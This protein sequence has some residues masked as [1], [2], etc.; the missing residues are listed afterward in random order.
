MRLADY[1]Y[2]AHFY[3]AGRLNGQEVIQENRQFGWRFFPPAAARTPRPVTL[4]HIKPAGTCRVFVFGESAA[5][6][7]PSPAFGMPRMLEVLLR[8]RYPNT[9]FEVV[10]AAM[11]AINSNVILPI[12]RDCAREQG[13][14]WV[15][16]M[17]NNEVVGPYGAGTVFGPQ[18]PSLGFIRASIALKATKMGQMFEGFWVWLRRAK[19]GLPSTISLELFLDHPLRPDDPLMAKV[20]AHFARNLGDI[21]E[22]GVRSG[23]K[24]VVSTVASNLKD[25]PP[26]ASLHR[27]DLSEAQKAEW[28]GFYQAGVKAETEG[29]WAAAA[30]AYGRAAGI[31]DHYAELRFR[32]GRAAWRSGDFEA[33]G[34]HFLAARDEDG[35]RVRADRRI[36]EIIRQVGSNRQ[37]QGIAFVDGNQALAKQSPH[38]V[39]G[40]ELLYEHVHL[41]FKGNY[42]LARSLAEAIESLKPTALAGGTAAVGDWLPE[43]GCASRLGLNDWNHYQTLR[44]LRER[45]EHPPFTGQ[46][47]H[48]ER[49]E[50]L[51]QEIA[52][53]RASLTPETLATA[54]Q[55]CRRAVSLNPDDWT[56]HQELAQLLGHGADKAAAVAEWERVVAVVPLYPEPHY[57]LGV[58]LSQQGRTAEAITELRRALKLKP[59]LHQALNALGSALA[60]QSRF[61]EAIPQYEQALR[62]KPDFADARVN[63]GV[64][65][66]QMGRNQEAKAQFE[67]ALHLEP[68]HLEASRHLGQ[69]LNQGGQLSEVAQNY[70]EAVQ[71]NPQDA[72]AHFKWGQALRALGRV[73]EARTQYAEA[74]RINPDFADAHCQL[75]FELAVQGKDTEAM[76]HF[77]EALRSKPDMSDAHLNLGVALAKKQRFAEAISQF[78]EVLRINPVDEQAR[79]YLE[80]ARRL[81]SRNK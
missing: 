62:L 36:N 58:L 63:L 76:E 3:L 38:Q 69:L 9:R 1:G 20:Y 10:N 32:Q 73:G 30:E 45:L 28:D 5:Y 67:E 26:F 81:Q 4:P 61:A 49:Y 16:Y 52:N 72:Q 56:L 44:I 78:Q 71:R 35:I 65:L 18:V 68:D 25:C 59:N 57:E 15:L 66:N 21:L 14:I 23:A 70:A 46:L 37:A 54:V 31:D 34:S 22:V 75:G 80:A 2:P 53:G 13:D 55:A 74:V 27:R 42:W 39:V 40:E 50:R 12:A 17:G 11:T 29:S 48:H 79:K 8:D 24:V 6:G 47:D 19:S 64:V 41:K 33:A 77:A 7:D 43:E 60:A 51:K